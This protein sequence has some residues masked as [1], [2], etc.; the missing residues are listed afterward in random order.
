MHAL[1]IAVKASVTVASA[2]IEV[3]AKDAASQS[4]YAKHGFKNLLDD[5][6]HMYLPMAT[7]REI[8]EQ[9]GA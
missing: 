9:R 8:I 3:D 6:L 1:K 7:A 4:F 2:V 5:P